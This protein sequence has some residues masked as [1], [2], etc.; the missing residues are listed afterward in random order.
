MIILDYTCSYR[1]Q[2]LPSLASK[3]SVIIKTSIM[4]KLLVLSE[5]IISRIPQD[6][7]VIYCTGL[8]IDKWC[9]EMK[10]V[11]TGEIRLTKRLLAN[12]ETCSGQSLDLAECTK[13]VSALKKESN[14]IIGIA[15]GEAKLEGLEL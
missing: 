4:H 11:S 3:L 12:G 13:L 9:L 5:G 14:E 2:Q 15:L 1:A 8:L 6:K 7:L 10:Q